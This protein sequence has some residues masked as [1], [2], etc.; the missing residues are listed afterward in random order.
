MLGADLHLVQCHQSYKDPNHYIHIAERMAEEFAGKKE[1]PGRSL[2]AAVRQSRQYGHSSLALPAMEIWEQTDGKVDGFVS[3]PLGTGGTIAGVSQTLK[4][5]NPSGKA[6]ALADPAGAV[7]LRL[8]Q[9][10]R[11]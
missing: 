7:A 8:L 4:E 11:N 9:S 5:Q 2:G 10:R 1:A 3:A 6:I